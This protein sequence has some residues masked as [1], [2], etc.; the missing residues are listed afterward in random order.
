M[1]TSLLTVETACTTAGCAVEGVARRVIVRTVAVG[2]AEVPTLMCL[3]CG[4]LLPVELKVAPGTGSE[5]VEQK[6]PDAEP[7]AGPAKVRKTGA[8]PRN[9]GRVRA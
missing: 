8:R 3:A 7:P 5:M 6:E 2:V 4:G 9:A 1:G